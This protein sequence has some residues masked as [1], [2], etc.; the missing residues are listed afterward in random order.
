MKSHCISFHCVHACR[1]FVHT[2][3]EFVLRLGEFVYIVWGVGP[4]LEEFV[5][6]FGVAAL[7]SAASFGIL[8]RADGL[9][10]L[11]Q[12]QN[13]PLRGSEFGNH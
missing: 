3:G 7:W 13:F 5:H 2:S 12:I 11:A 8:L 9:R 6:T 10:L 4:T 1:E